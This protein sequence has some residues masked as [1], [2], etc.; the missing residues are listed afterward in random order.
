[1]RDWS[2]K[3]IPSCATFKNAYKVRA[4]DAK[5]ESEQTPV[6]HSFTYLTRAN[7]PDGGRNLVTS[8]RLP[9]RMR[10]QDEDVSLRDVF[11]LVKS[12]L[13]SKELCQE[14][15]LVWPGYFLE[16]S[17][18][19]IREASYESAPAK[20]WSIEG[21]RLEELR[22]LGDSIAK[23]FPSYQR[24]VRFYQ[25]LRDGPPAGLRPPALSFMRNN[26]SHGNV[27]LHQFQLP[28][29]QAPLRPHQLQIVF[30][31]NP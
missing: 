2:G 6:P 28:E 11:C 31:R 29:R 3:L 5:E 20:S 19:C 13:S 18:K 22:L 17:Q 15:L 21:D 25:S 8:E 26:V 23:D 27:G 10:N 14:P 9:R 24:T 4:F 16:A 12:C 1:M 30:H 7:L